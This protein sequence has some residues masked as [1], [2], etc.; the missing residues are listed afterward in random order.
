MSEETGTV[1]LIDDDSSVR[2]THAKMLERGGFKVEPSPSARHALGL[3]ERG[4]RA[5]VIV[6][7][8]KMPEMNGIDFL[9]EVRRFDQDV[10]VIIVTGFPSLET[11]IRAIEY[12][13]F[14]YLTKPV[15]ASELNA[16]VRDGAALHR[17]AMLKRR[18]LELYDGR[19]SH[20]AD[21]AG[22]EGAFE[23]ALDRLWIALQPIVNWRKRE[24]IGYEALMRSNEPSLQDPEALLEAAQRLGR[25]RELGRRIRAQVVRAVEVAPVETLV[26]TNLHSADFNDDELYKRSTPLAACANRIVLEVTERASL[27]RVPDVRER[28]QA[29]RSLGFKIAIDDLGIGYAGLASFS[30]LQPDIAKLDTSLIRDIDLSS[31][32]RSI[33]GSMISVCRDDLGVQVICEGVETRAERDT[34]EQLGTEVVQGYLFGRPSPGFTQPDWTMNPPAN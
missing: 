23:R 19:R 22:L 25:L 9:R 1:L 20:F 21:R 2:R 17:M 32:K 15:P 14:R 29:L 16:A 30:Q 6:T 31:Q 4:L 5:S 7:D 3:V 8:L 11:A 18:A 26:F 27:D 33:V 28:V 10:P 24:I 13:G 12:G 34:L